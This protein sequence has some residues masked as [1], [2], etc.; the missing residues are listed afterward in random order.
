MKRKV[1]SI[2]LFSVLAL[3]L[4]VSLT[5]CGGSN[6]CKDGNHKLITMENCIPIEPDS[7]ETQENFPDFYEDYM[8][9]GDEIIYAKYHGVECENCSYQGVAPHDFKIGEKNEE[10][11]YLSCDCGKSVFEEHQTGVL[12]CKCGYEVPAFTAQFYETVNGVNYYWAT[13]VETAVGDVVIPDTY[14]DGVISLVK[15]PVTSDS[16]AKD[17]DV[18]GITSITLPASVENF[19][20][21]AS[22]LTKIVCKGETTL[23]N[24]DTP[25]LKELDAPKAKLSYYKGTSLASL[26]K[27]V[28][29]SLERTS[30]S[31]LKDC[32][33]DLEIT[34]NATTDGYIHCPTFVKTLNLGE[35]VTEMVAV[36]S[37]I[38]T[39]EQKATDKLQIINAPYLVK[40][41]DNG[42][43]GV[44]F[45]FNGDYLSPN[46]TTVNAPK[47]EVVADY[48]F[49]GL[50][51]LKN[52]DLP[53]LTEIGYCAFSRCGLESFTI[54]NTVTSISNFA[55]DGNENLKTLYYNA[56]NIERATSDYS[57][58]LNL[59]NQS[60]AEVEGGIKITIGKDVKTVPQG[61]CDSRYVTSVIFETGSAVE[62]ISASAFYEAT[63]ITSIT[64]PSTVTVIG[65]NAFSGCTALKT[66]ILPENLETIGIY[67][68]S[69]TGIETITIP[70]SVTQI[71]NSAFKWCDSLVTINAPSSVYIPIETVDLKLSFFEEENGHYYFRSTL[72]GL[73]S[74]VT[75]LCPREG[76][77]D[78]YLYGINDG[79]C[80]TI[81]NSRA[82]VTSLTVPVSLSNVSFTDFYNLTAVVI[83]E[84]ITDIAGFA[85]SNCEKLVNVTLPTT[86][87][88]I[89]TSA[90]LNTA[91]T[92]LNLPTG[93][94]EIGT[95]AFD[96]CKSLSSVT[97]PNT[98]V[99]I[100]NFAF[101][102]CD[103][104]EE[105]TLPSAL[106]TMGVNA[107]G[108][109][110]N[111]E[112]INVLGNFELTE[113][114]VANSNKYKGT[115]Y[116]NGYYIGKTLV[117][118]IDPTKF[119]YIK[120]GTTKIKNGVF[121]G[122][123]QIKYVYV[124]ATVTEHGEW[125]FEDCANLTLILQGDNFS[126]LTSHG[127]TGLDRI[128][129]DKCVTEDGFEYIDNTNGITISKYFG[130]NSVVEIPETINGK[131]IAAVGAGNTTSA[132]ALVDANKLTVTKVIMPDTVGSIAPLAFLNMTDLVEVNI[133][134]SVAG[135]GINAFSGCTSLT[136]VNVDFYTLQ[137]LEELG[138]T[139]VTEGM[140]KFTAYEIGQ[141]NAIAKETLTYNDAQFITKLTT[142]Y[143]ECYWFRYG[144]PF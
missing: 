20:I 117:G 28:I 59:L 77:K 135:I 105:I 70:G 62:K 23:V 27:L 127:L 31:V 4:S 141:Y 17:K 95:Q 33:K 43:G 83:S 96:G 21:Y 15:G 136:T 102:N 98:V 125:V 3:L 67:A 64:L 42:N 16:P 35:G 32:P 111:L 131:K 120:D 61:F 44:S 45:G 68:F 78:I 130:D 119:L 112:T 39:D 139:G 100:G 123:T 6:G 46:I 121:D 79:D 128:R 69:Q 137:E 30:F 99:T 73:K 133:P 24:F 93:V 49:S 53:A 109:C 108:H 71:G 129:H 104:L 40:I 38:L 114:M 101:F 34:V 14:E 1:F 37:Q 92:E 85:F 57:T 29:G 56:K 118:V 36:R 103:L 122:L 80:I 25:S 54:P 18:S 144:T 65:D 82:N 143:A 115:A 2:I 74:T 94:T 90:F 84:G 138:I 113:E 110:D 9:F 140:L 26:E 86:L 51:G 47:L 41:K 75:E 66:V 7:E 132:E 97:L 11:H 48:S 134:A 58:S 124:P 19:S 12:N 5:A 8:N 91:I 10:G 22:N 116:L 88:T 63:G 55:L 126:S 76:T 142:T 60:G 50:I 72:V 52:L 89:K 13:V 107:L 106:Q 87:K 81:Y